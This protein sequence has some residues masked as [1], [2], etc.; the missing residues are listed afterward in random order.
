MTFLFSC[1]YF[2]INI[3]VLWIILLLFWLLCYNGAMKT[4]TVIHKV[5][6]IA[7]LF[8][9]LL[10]I[11]DYFYALNSTN[12]ANSGLTA[13][14]TVDTTSTL[15]ISE[16][17]IALDI[18]PSVEG[19]F[20]SAHTTVGTYTNTT[21]AC[22]VTM[23][24][25]FTDLVS[26]ADSIA[27]LSDAVSEADFTD[28]RW[29]YRIGSS[30]NYGAVETNNEIASFE[31]KTGSTAYSSDIYF[32]AK[33]T[34]ATRPGAYS[35]TVTFMSTCL[36][37]PSK[38]YMQDF[39]LEE[40]QEY[41]TDENYTLYDRRDDN[42]YTVRYIEGACWMT[43]NLRI[44]GTVSSED[45]NFSTYSSV[46]VCESDL[47]AGNSTTQPRCHD[48]GNIT[49]GAWYNFA[50][51]SARTNSVSTSP[52]ME[53]ICPAGWSLPSYS[54]ADAPGSA[55]SLVNTAST[56]IAKFSPSITGDY[57]DGILHELDSG[58]WWVNSGN[59]VS[60]YYIHY[61]GTQL[62]LYNYVGQQ[63]GFHV[64]CVRI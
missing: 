3:E 17:N 11:V 12:A 4:K 33:L 36:P 56:S 9:G 39:T 61:R 55:N 40:C 26:G 50:A 30:G 14:A 23:T 5:L 32:A 19:T 34:P 49:A 53:D 57:I 13:I 16:D 59:S 64:R 43:Q 60:H 47:T 7:V 25:S 28:D 22:T 24:T 18:V 31:Q 54:N 51:A 8:V 6:V 10:N 38:T 21:G 44:T 35:N 42:D 48:S 52:Y 1:F 15:V 20:K 45:S 27:T 62:N 37:P 63:F 58:V 41:A 46:N 29:G 2:N